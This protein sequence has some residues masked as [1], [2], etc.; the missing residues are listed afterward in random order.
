MKHIISIIVA[1]ALWGTIGLYVGDLTSLGLSRISLIAVRSLV[2]AAAMLIWLLATDRKKLRVRPRDLW[3]FVGTGIFS[4]TFFNICYLGAMGMVGLGVAAILLYT[5]PVFIMLMSAVFFHEKLTSGKLLALGLAITGCALVSGGGGGE[6]KPLGLLLGTLS[7]FGYALYSIFGSVALKRYSSATV[8][9]YTFVFA[10]LCCIP[11]SSPLQFYGLVSAMPD[12]GVVVLKLALLGLLTGAVP[13]LLYTYGLSGVVASKA[14][15]I[16]CV[17]P[18]VAA[19][20]GIAVYGEK[21]RLISL[22]GMLL[23][24]SAVVVINAAGR[25]KSKDI[26]PEAGG[27][28]S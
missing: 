7:G 8:T 21:P 18:V 4:F 19:V 2:S 17:E 9:F 10:S 28:V 26:R 15:I 12:A 27:S 16:A 25:R 13:Y 1:A 5:A 23:V 22:A 6:L 3:M 24:L 14:S 11:L 20:L